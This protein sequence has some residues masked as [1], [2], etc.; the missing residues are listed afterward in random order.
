MDRKPAYGVAAPPTATQHQQQYQQQTAQFSAPPL[1]SASAQ[2]QLQATAQSL[3]KSGKGFLG[4]IAS[5]IK[6]KYPA[7]SNATAPSSTTSYTGEAPKPTYNPAQHPNQTP[8]SPTNSF[9]QGYGQSQQ[10]TPQHASPTPQQSIPPS[11]PGYPPI[12]HQGSFP[13]PQGIPGQLSQ[14][15]HHAPQQL[16][17]QIQA[18]ANGVA[19]AQ[20]ATSQPPV[21]SLGAA[22]LPYAQPSPQHQLSDPCAPTAPTQATQPVA[23]VTPYGVLPAYG[24]SPSQVIPQQQNDPSPSSHGNPPPSWPHQTGHATYSPAGATPSSGSAGQATV[25]VGAPSYGPIGVHPQ[26]P[27]HHNGPIPHASP[28][29]AQAILPMPQPEV[30]FSQAHSPSQIASPPPQQQ[31]QSTI[32]PAYHQPH[33][34]QQAPLAQQHGQLTALEIKPPSQVAPYLSDQTSS[35]NYAQGNHSSPPSQYHSDGT[36]I[37]QAQQSAPSQQAHYQSPSQAHPQSTTYAPGAGQQAVTPDQ[38]HAPLPSSPLQNLNRPSGILPSAPEA[39]IQHQVYS[40]PAVQQAPQTNYGQPLNHAPTIAAHNQYHQQPAPQAPAPAPAAEGQSFQPYQPAEQPVNSY[41]SVPAAGQRADNVYHQDPLASLSAQMNNLNVQ[42]GEQRQ[43]TPGT[44]PVHEKDG[45][46]GPPPC[47]GTGMASDTLPY[48]PESRVV[49]YALDWYR[50]TA[51]PQYLVCTRCYEDNVTGTQLAINFERYHSP[52]GTESKCGFWSPRARE[53]LWL[54]A[55]QSNDIGPLRAFAEKTLTLP[56]CKGRVWS[57]AADGVKWWGMV[58]NEVDGFISCEACYEDRIVGTA[59]EARFSP[60]RQ[61][62]PDEKWMCDLCIP[63]IA[64]V[65]VKMTKT[66]NWSGFTEAVKSRIHLPVCEGRDEESN[67]GRWILPRRRIDN[68]R[69]CEACY[70]DKLA[71]TCF[72]N[73]FERHQRAEGF[74]AFLESL[75]QK[76]KCSLTDTA[77]NMSIALK[78]ALYRRDFNVFWNAASAICSLVPCT[79]NGIIGGNWWTVTGGYPDFDVCEAC[80]KGALETSDLGRFF[81][82]AK[83][84]P[85]ATITCNFCP[86]SP[87]WGTFITKFAEALDKGIFSYYSDYVRKW[88]GVQTCPGIKNRDKSKWWGH[89]EALACEDCWLSFVADTSLGDTV[90]VKGVYDERTLICQL[91]SPRMR[92]MWLSACAAGPPGSPESQKALDEF[93]AFGTKRVQVYNATVPHIEMIRSMMMMKRMQAMQQGQLSLMYQGMNGMSSIMGTTDG[94]LHGN[95]SIGYYETENGV[96]AANMMNN[97]HAGM[98]DSNKMSDWMQMAQLQA[99]WMEVE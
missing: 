90:P 69:I 19:G 92:N 12:S 24:Q 43:P 94:Y 52:E 73:E 71:L 7:T 47:L 81:E 20:S 38:S 9:P 88:A 49:A 32:S 16:H 78:A 97:M 48:C 42:N 27:Y 96:T 80:Y 11:A 82:P 1:A 25:Q 41:Q 58:N 91:W 39:G 18:P 40:A 77:V 70:L 99:T 87:R 62:G 67:N 22:A 79:A 45:P 68:M 15:R 93:R 35:A 95:S 4:N 61:Q 98:A 72:G 8:L 53:V 65:V 83:R 28:S 85:T 33:L 50:L 76:W 84:D 89:P 56:S 66:N 44:A 5:N 74:D 59:F 60:Y 13:Q 36:P 37:V 21:H 57:T 64:T 54:Q 75:G 6:S 31:Y 55:L 3:L 2:G 34:Q 30:T 51:V 14:K 17:H 29:S 63:Y 46:R 10:A 26:P 23:Q 86:G